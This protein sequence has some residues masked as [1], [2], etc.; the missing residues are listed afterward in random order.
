M[1]MDVPISPRSMSEEAYQHKI[2]CVYIGN[3]S[4]FRRVKRKAK[5]E[6][7]IV[8]LS[9][10]ADVVNVGKELFIRFNQMEDVEKALSEMT[11]ELV[12]YQDCVNY[13]IR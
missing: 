8:F 5:I 7:G 9:I 11:E 13:G 4:F 6:E 2:E 1:S 3:T 12:C 10:K